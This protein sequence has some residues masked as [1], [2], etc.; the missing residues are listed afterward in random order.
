MITP[1]AVIINEL[2]PEG[3]PIVN[4]VVGAVTDSTESEA[5]ET[6]G[7]ATSLQK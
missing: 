4:P 5:G 6:L 7:E 2:P 3:L 1:G